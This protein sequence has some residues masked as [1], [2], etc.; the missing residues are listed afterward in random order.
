MV[1]DTLDLPGVGDAKVLLL[2][3]TVITLMTQLRC[4]LTDLSGGIYTDVF[5]GRIHKNKSAYFIYNLITYRELM[6]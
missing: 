3:R 4:S 2:Y 1:W 6:I 5:K